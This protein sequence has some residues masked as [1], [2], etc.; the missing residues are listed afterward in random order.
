MNSLKYSL[1][2]E[3]LSIEQKR[4]ITSLIQKKE[5]IRLFL[6]NWKPIT[7]LNSDYIILTKAL[8]N[9]LC[10]LLPH[11]INKD[12]TGYIKGSFI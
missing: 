11:I 8:A 4:G 2:K 9:R 1:S 12:Q 6:Q 10:Y 5:K 3:E 7:L